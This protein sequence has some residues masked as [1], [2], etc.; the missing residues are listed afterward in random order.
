MLRPL[1]SRCGTGLQR[2]AL[3][4]AAGAALHGL[5]PRLQ[6]VDLAGGAVLAPFDVHRRAVMLFDDERL[7]RQAR[8]FGLAQREAVAAP[9]ARHRRCARARREPGSAYTILMALPPRFLRRIA[10]LPARSAGLYT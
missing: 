10:R 5:G 6:D 3:D 2:E 9:R 8:R 1:T 4:G 7:F